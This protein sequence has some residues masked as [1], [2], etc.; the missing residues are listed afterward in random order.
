MII[1]GLE[2]TVWGLFLGRLNDQHTRFPVPFFS[3]VH[4]DCSLILNFP[5]S[6]VSF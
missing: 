6:L 5:Q 3:L 4:T 1:C 2:S